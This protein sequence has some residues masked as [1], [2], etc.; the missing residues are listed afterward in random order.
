MYNSQNLPLSKKKIIKK[1][2]ESG[3]MLPMLLLAVLFPA[4]SFMGSKL[5]FHIGN[6]AAFYT[7]LVLFVPSLLIL[8][9]G[10]GWQYLYYKYYYYNFEQDGA[11]IK[12]G[13]ISNA[14]GHVRYGK[15]Q[16][17]YLDQDFLDR[18]FGLYDVHYETAGE[19]SNFYSHVD[20]LEKENADKLVTFL[21]ERV[22][23]KDYQAKPTSSIDIEK[24]GVD[25]ILNE[26]DQRTFTRENIPIEKKI[27]L[28]NVVIKTV[29]HLVVL[30]IGVAYI[31]NKLGDVLNIP[32]PIWGYVLIL[33]PILILIWNYVMASIWYKNYYFKFDSKGGIITEKVLASN[34]TQVYFNRVQ[35]ID[36]S[37]SVVERMM[38]LYEVTM[39]TAA[40]GSGANSITITG[41]KKENAETLRDFLL[42]STKKYQSI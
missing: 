3:G 6:T 38:G 13:V 30:F 24:Q 17:I 9:I 28:A 22:Q 20:G 7:F 23:N 8:L 25:A 21:N 26:N 5:E 1:T 14:T 19:S 35:N 37:Q 29:F 32:A 10:L 31:E 41:I 12:K 4:I 18:V 34:T 36:I 15:I 39:E 42:E 11:E 40:E 27:I 2:L 33:A 16:N